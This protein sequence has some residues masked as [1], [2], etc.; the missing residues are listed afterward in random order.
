MANLYKCCKFQGF[1]SSVTENSIILGCGTETLGKWLL[2]FLRR[3][4]P[5][6]CWEALPATQHHM[7]GAES[8]VKFVFLSN[9]C[10]P[11]NLQIFRTYNQQMHHVF[12]T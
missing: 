12:D 7:P 4:F 1:H 6:K 2:T 11:C 10:A 9:L 3:Y 8:F 5:M